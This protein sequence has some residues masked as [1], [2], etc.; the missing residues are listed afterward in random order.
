MTKFKQKETAF[1]NK[2]GFGGYVV[3]I[4][5]VLPKKRFRPQKY[6]IGTSDAGIFDVVPERKLEKWSSNDQSE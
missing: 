1:Y 6:L 3:C 4:K 5:G 2:W